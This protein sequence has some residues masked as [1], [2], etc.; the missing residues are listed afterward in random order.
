MSDHGSATWWSRLRIQ[1][2]V[3]AVL[4]LL[5]RHARPV[6]GSGPGEAVEEDLDWPDDETAD[7]DGTPPG[8]PEPVAAD[9]VTADAVTAAPEVPADP[10]VPSPSLDPDR[11]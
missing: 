10:E 1:H 3:W 7:D 2:K 5:Y 8:G 9:A 6:R 4:L 11:R